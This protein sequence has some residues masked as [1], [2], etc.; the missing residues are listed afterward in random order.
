MIV[1][2]NCNRQVLGSL[3]LNPFFL[4]ESDKYNLTPQDFSNKFDKKIFKAI[5]TLYANGAKTLETKF[6]LSSL[7]GLNIYKIYKNWQK[8]ITFI[9]II[10][11]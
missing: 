4:S 6:F 7:M 1:D 10:I 11:F 8:L 3:M 2:K 5:Y 9:F